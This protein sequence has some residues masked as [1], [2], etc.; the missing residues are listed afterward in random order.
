ME[1]SAALALSL[2]RSAA[3]WR[4]ADTFPSSRVE[5]NSLVTGGDKPG[6]ALL[7]RHCGHRLAGVVVGV[8]S[9]GGHLGLG[10]LAQLVAS[11]I[12]VLLGVAE[13]G[14]LGQLGQGVAALTS[15]VVA[16]D[17]TRVGADH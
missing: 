17:R 5:V 3:L 4:P 7:G 15:V 9:W 11:A 14:E 12:D 13:G 8:A 16:L 10:K 2:R 6:H 1:S